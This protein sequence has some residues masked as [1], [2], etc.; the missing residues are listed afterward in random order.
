MNAAMFL[1]GGHIQRK[2]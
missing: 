2:T 1:L